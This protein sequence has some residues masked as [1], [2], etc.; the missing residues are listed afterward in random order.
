MGGLDAVVFTAGVGENQAIVREKSTQG[1]EFLGID[2]DT[3]AN[4]AVHR[5]AG[6]TCLSRPSSRVKV[7]LIPTNEEL[8]IA[9]DT[10]EIAS[11]I[12]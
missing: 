10:A 11:H 2:F 3:E 5:P 6:V 9:M 7:Y 1:L 12:R 4:N 8:V